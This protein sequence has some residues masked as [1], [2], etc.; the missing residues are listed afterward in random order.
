[1][2]VGIKPIILLLGGRRQAKVFAEGGGG[3]QS[4]GGKEMEA[5]EEGMGKGRQSNRYK[6]AMLA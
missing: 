2:F 5:G 4:E 3:G 6:K 1:M